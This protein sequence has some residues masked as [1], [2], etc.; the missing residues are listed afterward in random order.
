M[1][2]LKL[3]APQD[4]AQ[5]FAA[6]LDRCRFAD[7]PTEVTDCAVSGGPDSTALAVLAVAAG[8][9]PTLHHVD[10]GLRDGSGDEAF[11]VERLADALGLEFVGH[12]VHVA[13]G[14]NLEA[15]CR[16]ARFGV[17]PDGVVTGH[18]ADDQAETILMN[19]MRGAGSTGLSAM[20]AVD[21]DSSHRHPILGLRREE[22]HR[23]C[24]DLGINVVVD[25]TN[26]DPAFTRNRVRHELVP[27]LN[28]IAAR[29]V[30][31]VLTRQA[32]LIGAEVALI[33]T[34]AAT[35]DPTDAK[36]VADAPEAV[37]RHVL[38]DFIVA[39]TAN[40][41]PPDAA[42]IGRVLD[43]ARGVAVGTDIGGGWRLQ[44]SQQRLTIVGPIARPR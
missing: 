30:V 24:A 35:I 37:A 27:L 25:P 10:H 4:L 28:D 12:A 42:T 43:V 14:P 2:A 6:L 34:L 22:T 18:T 32:D 40:E 3:P 17:L 20:S 5:Q 44:R 41:H 9:R 7:S 33:A 13:P 16:E 26:D 11:L 1:S 39:E 29:D 15:R 21:D 38:R 23:V 8:L 36:A 31:T 19:L